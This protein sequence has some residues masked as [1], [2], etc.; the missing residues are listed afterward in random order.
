V[1]EYLAGAIVAALLVAAG[2]AH[3]RIPAAVGAAKAGP[4]GP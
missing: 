2:Y 4:R 3:Y 1:P